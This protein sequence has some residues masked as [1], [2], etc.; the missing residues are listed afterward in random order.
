MWAVAEK[1]GAL[2]QRLD[3]P[4]F[5][6][7]TYRRGASGIPTPVIR[8]V[9]IRVQTLVVAAEQWPMTPDA[10]AA[11]YGVSVALVEEVLAFYAAHR[12]EIDQAL[13][14]EQVQEPIYA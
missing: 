7:I 10:I 12:D 9:G 5:P 11:D 4:D 1:V 2:G 6:H 3:D 8:G 14:G 13:V